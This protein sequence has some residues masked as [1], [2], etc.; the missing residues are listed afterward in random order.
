MRAGIAHIRQ[1]DSIVLQSAHPFKHSEIVSTLPEAT[2]DTLNLR[3]MVYELLRARPEQK[4]TARQLADLVFAARPDACQAKKQHSRNLS[5][6]ADLLQQIAGEISAQ[7]PRLLFAHPEI[8]ATESRPRQYYYTEQ[9]ESAE[10]EAAE[11]AAS[12]P[13]AGDSGRKQPAEHA[14]YPILSEYLWA[15]FGIY[16]MRIDEKRSKNSR[17]KNG[18]RW[19]HPDVVGMV[20]LGEIWHAEIRDCASL[21][22][23][24]RTQLWSFEVKLMINGSNLRESFFQAVSNSSWA[25]FGY[26]V[27]PVISG[28][29]TLRELR[30]LC[31]AHGIG[32][33]P[34]DEATPADSV[35]LIPV[36]HR[37]HRRRNVPKSTGTWPI[38][39]PRKTATF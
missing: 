4:F 18:N 17:G 27:A 10:V 13:Q 39:W 37:S 21:H 38:G 22:A 23:D 16:S 19:L 25:N 7:R 15:E 5:T 14:L 24:K 30:M 34:L 31:A 26:L 6:D 35:V 12:T 29:H 11:Q 3:Q 33:I 9:S 8:K 2:P 32:F 1:Q 20:D 36:P 28:P